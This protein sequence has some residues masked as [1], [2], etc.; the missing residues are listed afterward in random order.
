MSDPW[1]WDETGESARRGAW[2]VVEIGGYTIPPKWTSG[3]GEQLKPD[4]LGT[5][6][7]DLGPVA[8]VI[9]CTTE[10][11]TCGASEDVL[12]PGTGPVCTLPPHGPEREHEA[13]DLERP[14][15]DPRRI[16]S[17]WR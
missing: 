17:V 5:S 12:G 7:R 9:V 6:W 1:N 8:G 16:V 11:S 2:S 10:E 14:E 4:S 15:G 3:P 13:H